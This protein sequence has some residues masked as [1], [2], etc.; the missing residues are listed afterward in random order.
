MQLVPSLLTMTWLQGNHL[1]GGGEK[2]MNEIL[3]VADRRPLGVRSS[4]N[5]NARR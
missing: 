4:P 1:S 2:S 3:Y 5:G